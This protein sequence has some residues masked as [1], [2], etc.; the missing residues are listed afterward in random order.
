MDVQGRLDCTPS[1]LERQAAGI[2]LD[3]GDPIEHV[4][5]LGGKIRNARPSMLLDFNLKRR[6]EVDAIIG[7]VAV[8]GEKYSVDTPVTRTVANIIRARESSYL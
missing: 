4:R 3:V 6:G 1:R 5:T 7:Q 2:T 8:L